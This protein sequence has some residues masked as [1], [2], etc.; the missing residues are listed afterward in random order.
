MI[1]IDK[2]LTHAQLYCI[3]DKCCQT[4]T[5]ASGVKNTSFLLDT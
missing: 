5:H 4:C 2:E 3:I 1:G